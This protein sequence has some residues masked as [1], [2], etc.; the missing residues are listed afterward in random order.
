MEIGELETVEENGRI[1]VFREIK[2]NKVAGGFNAQLIAALRDSNGVLVN[3]VTSDKETIEIGLA[4]GGS[5]NI[6]IVFDNCLYIFDFC[7]LFLRNI[8]SV[9][10]NPYCQSISQ[11]LTGQPQQDQ[12]QCPI[13]KFLI[14]RV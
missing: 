11:L 2:N 7:I 13:E 14:F 3:L 10:C 6:G 12:T 4:D 9:Y 1:Y 5:G 8:D